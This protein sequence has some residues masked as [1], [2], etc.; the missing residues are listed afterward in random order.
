[1]P[2]TVLT[3]KQT[4]TIRKKLTE[5]D[6]LRGEILGILD[7]A[8]APVSPAVRS[9]KKPGRPRKNKPAD[10]AATAADIAG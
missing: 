1:M 7:A 4:D 3:D 5:I 8:T 2:Y 6:T 10:S 9:D